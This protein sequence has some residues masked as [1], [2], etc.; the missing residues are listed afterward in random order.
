MLKPHQTGL[1]AAALALLLAS[2]NQST[3][4]IF[5]FIE[6]EQKIAAG[7]LGSTRTVATMAKDPTRYFVAGGTTLAYRT[8]ETTTTEWKT[9]SVTGV[10]GEVVQAVR[11]LNAGGV[12]ALAGVGTGAAVYLLE[13]TS[14]DVWKKVSLAGGQ[15]PVNLVPVVDSDGTSVV[16]ILV[17]TEVPAP[18]GSTGKNYRHVYRLSGGV[19]ATAGDLG[20]DIGT[21]VV[22]AIQTGSSYYLVNRTTMWQTG[23]N[24]SSPLEVTGL[25]STNGYNGLLAV[26][27]SATLDGVY[28]STLRKNATGGS[29]LKGSLSDNAW[30]SATTA[31]TGATEKK[32]SAGNALD[33]GPLSLP[34]A[35]ADAVS[36]LVGTDKAGFAE[37]IGTTLTIGST[38]YAKSSYDSGALAAAAVLNFFVDGTTLFVGTSGAGL[39]KYN[40]ASS[41]VWSVE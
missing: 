13:S 11:S 34:S 36:L 38:S 41:T 25:P 21:P 28:L 37:I 18:A 24:L 29:V 22:A 6:A 8:T 14:P 30:T 39:W 10:A 33:L 12:Y 1:L 17:V 40:S 19:D 3:T 15:T 20:A 16:A 9:L 26:S 7:N 31:L 4:G 5:A 2:C 23:T 27:G 32:D 35:P